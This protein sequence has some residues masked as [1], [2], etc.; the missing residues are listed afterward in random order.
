[1]QLHPIHHIWWNGARVTKVESYHFKYDL[2]ILLKQ[3]L[4]FSVGPATTKTR[5]Y[6]TENMLTPI[7]LFKTMTLQS[8][9]LY[10]FAPGDYV[11][12][13]L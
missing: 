2:Q 7:T 10:E 13:Q 6:S 8:A 9:H 11:E 1:M 4:D 3:T 12:V 5:V